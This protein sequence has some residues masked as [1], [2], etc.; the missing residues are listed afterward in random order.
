M[1]DLSA[2]QETILRV[3]AITGDD[4]PQHPEGAL[5]ELDEDYPQQP[6][7]EDIKCCSFEEVREFYDTGRPENLKLL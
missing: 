6:K 5:G 3:A 7:Q 1:T 2:R 4:D